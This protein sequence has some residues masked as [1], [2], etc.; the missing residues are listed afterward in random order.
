MPEPRALI[1]IEV[2]E[3]VSDCPLKDDAVLRLIDRR[4]M[5][6]PVREIATDTHCHMVELDREGPV[7]RERIGENRKFF[8]Q[9]FN[10]L[11]L[12]SAE[13]GQGNSEWREAGRDVA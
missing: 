11:H 10:Y 4:P 7:V 3:V 5:L 13:V 6:I 12:D 9:R 8:A 1:R 2:A